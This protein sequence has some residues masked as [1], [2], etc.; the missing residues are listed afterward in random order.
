MEANAPV[1]PGDAG[2]Q[3]RVVR[4]VFFLILFFFFPIVPPVSRPVKLTMVKGR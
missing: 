1:L 3:T 4:M 2:A